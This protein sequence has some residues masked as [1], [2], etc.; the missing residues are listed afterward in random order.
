MANDIPTKDYFGAP[1]RRATAQKT[2]DDLKDENFESYKVINASDELENLVE[3]KVDYSSP[4]KFVTYGSAEE[5]YSSGIKNIYN[6]YPYDGSK[7]EKI[8]WHVTS[9]GLD[10][11]LFEKEYPRNN[12]H[13]AISHAGWGTT[14][15]TDDGGKYALPTNKEYITVFGGPN[16][17]P[18]SNTLAKLFPSFGGK[19]NIIDASENRESNLTL[20]GTDGNTIEFWM[21]KDAFHATGQQEIVFDMWASGS[22]QGTSE[23]GRMCVYLNNN[24]TDPCLGLAYISG[25]V[26]IQDT[27]VTTTT[28]SIA[29]GNWHHYAIAID[30]T[31]GT[32]D[33]YL[34][35]TKKERITGTPIGEV[36]G[37]LVANIGAYYEARPADGLSLSTGFEE[38]WW[39][40]T[41]AEI[42]PLNSFSTPPSVFELDAFGNL[43]PLASPTGNAIW[44][45][46]GSGDLMPDGDVDVSSFPVIT[47][48][49]CKLSA[50]LDDFRFWKAERTGEQIGI[51]WNTQVF[52]GTNTDDANTTLGVYYKFNEGIT[53]I[54]SYDSSVLDYSGRISN[55]TWTG[56]SSGARS[57]TSAMVESNAARSEFKD[58]VVYS[59]HP[60]VTSLLATKQATGLEYDQQNNSSLY[61]SLP[62]WIR[63]DDSAQQNTL[64]LTQVMSS[65]LDTL[66]NQITEVKNIKNLAYPSGSQKPYN[67]VKRNVQNLGFDTADFFIDATV[68]ERFMDRNEQQDFENNLN[69]TKNL[70]YQNIYNNLA[71]I[72]SSKGTEKSFRN[73][74][75]CFGI[76]EKLL[77]LKVYSNN[78][79]YKL[80]DRYENRTIK[81]RMVSFANP[82]RFEASLFQTTSS[83]APNQSYITA[84]G[85]F[86]KL[87]GTTIEGEFIFPEQKT[88]GSSFFFDTPFTK[89]SLFGTKEASSDSFT[90]A[91]TDNADLQVYAVREQRNSANAYFQLTSSQLGIN[92]TSSIYGDVYDNEKWNLAV[93]VKNPTLSS[94]TTDNYVIEF[95]GVNSAGD[96]INNS[97]SLS[98]EITSVQAA[99]FHAA[100]KRVYAGAYRTNFTGSVIDKADT[101]ASSIRYWEKYLTADE[102][103][104]HAKD[105]KNFGLKDPNRPV[106][107]AANDMPAIDTLKLHW[108]F[109]LVSTSDSTGLFD[110][111]DLSSGSAD[112][113]SLY[114]D[115]GNNHDGTGYGFPASST[116]VV[117]LEYVDTLVRTNPEVSNGSDMVKVLTNS[118]EIREENSV[119]TNH[120]FNIEKSLYETISD[121]MIRYF[122]TERDFASLYLSAADKYKAQHAELELMR[123]EFF[124]KME[125]SPNAEEFYD[126]FKWIDDAVV[127][128]L[129]QQLPAG[130]ELINGSANIIESHVLERNNIEHKVPTYAVSS[131]LAPM[132]IVKSGHDT[133]T[134]SGLFGKEE[135]FNGSFWDSRAFT[136]LP[137]L[138]ATGDTNV[139]A[140]RLR[141]L[142]VVN[143][144]AKTVSTMKA[145]ENTT[146]VYNK[147][148]ADEI[149]ADLTTNSDSLSSFNVGE[150]KVKLLFKVE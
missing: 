132:G 114:G 88:P 6:S 105:A 116:S 119:P 61:N 16:K 112:K 109:E 37:A 63:E 38:G 19:S 139:D 146:V 5:Y 143:N 100:G 52:G 58:P 136:G 148:T 34:D 39:S 12:G 73:L 69:D 97:F 92:L 72:M 65:Y 130:A 50:S 120:V 25:T 81:K 121:E 93:K 36:Q 135:E 118:A 90:W 68:L 84:G 18:D 140:D 31:A 78:E 56:Y 62:M 74:A 137:L 13:I 7:Y 145:E 1:G 14:A 133:G 60:D 43:M 45:L 138:I 107:N 23:Y 144:V 67:F 48:G 53:Q 17:D 79:E 26:G 71:Y 89:S 102:I 40:S 2:R 106:F 101:L 123:R 9:S 141:I 127:A 115:F 76:D 3:P 21:K 4:E 96:R 77:K 15:A 128:M 124:S 27:F 85:D 30:A 111:L 11:H 47:P 24:L 108:D 75:R 82:R 126:Y 122:S 103:T 117:D 86:G 59:I 147:N 55:G 29:D 80:E 83:T 33:L 32:A 66:Q 42:S 41:A 51:N 35:G 91:A 104:S 54:N 28:S 99:A 8:Q 10:N 134:G 125:N 46:D 150:N 57:L 113:V 94:T 49:W 95:Q 20:G 70:I 98:T 142:N 22:A 44:D 64:K 129:K 110:V 149:S 87:H 131:S